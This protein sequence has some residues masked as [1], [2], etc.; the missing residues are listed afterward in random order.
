MMGGQHPL[1]QKVAI[2]L[3]GVCPQSASGEIFCPQ[4][5]SLARQEKFAVESYDLNRIFADF[6][7]FWRCFL[8]IKSDTGKRLQMTWNI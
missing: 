7:E 6:C 3:F 2:R 5:A 8:K 4:S 1:L